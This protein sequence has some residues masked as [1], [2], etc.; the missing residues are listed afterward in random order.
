MPRATSNKSMRTERPIKAIRRTS[1][2][3]GE[4]DEQNRVPG[5]A[6]R[7]QAKRRPGRTASLL[8]SVATKR[9]NRWRNP[10]RGGPRRRRGNL[11]KGSR[12]KQR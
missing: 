1:V 4:V 11:A 3:D 10:E 9:S 12:T 6:G 8:S 5:A 2:A 7:R